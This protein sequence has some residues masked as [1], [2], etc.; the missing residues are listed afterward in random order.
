MAT[1]NVAVVLRTEGAVGPL[2]P[3]LQ[4]LCRNGEVVSQLVMKG[5]RNGFFV[6]KHCEMS[7]HN[8]IDCTSLTSHDMCN[9]HQVLIV[10][11][12]CSYSIGTSFITILLCYPPSVHRFMFL[13]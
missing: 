1:C 9:G 7:P 10:Q 11:L 5:L 6:Y 13:T 12:S 2:S 4:I 3:V 8:A